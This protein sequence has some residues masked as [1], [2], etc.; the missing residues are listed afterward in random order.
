MIP[1]QYYDS[2]WQA[3]VDAGR[4]GETAIHR[5]IERIVRRRVPLQSSILDCG[6]GPGHY[7]RALGNDY[8][9]AGVE[10]SPLALARLTFDT[11]CIKVADLNLGI[12]DFGKTFDCIIASMILHHL[13]EPER[14]IE[15]ACVRL[16]K[17]GHFLVAHPNLDYCRGRLSLLTGK[18]R[19]ISPEHRSFR[20]NGEMQ[21]MLRN[22]G[23]SIAAVTSPKRKPLPS[24]FSRDLIYV[25]VK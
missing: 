6:V 20:Q 11:S 21:R 17:G 5:R 12:P 22:A 9:M 23:F 25:C 15:S 7:F 13:R 18:P 3:R 1:A 19:Y 8:R 4:T 10:V 2:Y 16:R 14:L 24:I